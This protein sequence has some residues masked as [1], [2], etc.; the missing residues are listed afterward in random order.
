[1]CSGGEDT[2]SKASHQPIIEHLPSSKIGH[3]T[4]T[5]QRSRRE[6]L[7]DS[8]AGNVSVRKDE[9]REPEYQSVPQ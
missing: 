9:A 2:F 6:V 8:L 5:S 7:M 1:M 4:T 3:P